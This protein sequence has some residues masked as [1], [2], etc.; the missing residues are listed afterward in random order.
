MVLNAVD[1]TSTIHTLLFNTCIFARATSESIWG[2]IA[3]LH[4]YHIL[5]FKYD[6][7]AL[8][9]WQVKHQE[10]LNV[11]SEWF[12]RVSIPEIPMQDL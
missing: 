10:N 6:F 2:I 11:L 5:H 9:E 8:V 7:V 1:L 4:C 3:T 12:L